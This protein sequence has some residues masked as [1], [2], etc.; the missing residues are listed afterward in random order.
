MDLPIHWLVHHEHSAS[1]VATLAKTE[2]AR[3]PTAM[4]GDVP[5]RLLR[6]A[7]NA[8]LSHS[9]CDVH[10]CMFSV[11]ISGLLCSLTDDSHVNATAPCMH[12]Y[13]LHAHALRSGLPSNVLHS[14]S[15]YIQWASQINVV[16]ITK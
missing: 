13:A 14:T 1:S 3:G 7:I 12:A 10:E 2:T 5:G 11:I 15:N 9:C 4:A 16:I 6:S 8:N